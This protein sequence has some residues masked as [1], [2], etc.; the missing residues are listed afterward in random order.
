MSYPPR[1]SVEIKVTLISTEVAKFLLD[2]A[3]DVT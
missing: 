1:V 3:S 2:F